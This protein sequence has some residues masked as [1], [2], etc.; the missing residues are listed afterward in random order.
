MGSGQCPGGDRWTDGQLL[1]G[2]STSAPSSWRSWSQGAWSVKQGLHPSPRTKSLHGH[3]LGLLPAGGATTHT[4]TRET[5]S[6]RLLFL[7][8]P[9][10]FTF[11]ASFTGTACGMKSNADY[12]KTS[13]IHFSSVSILPLCALLLKRSINTLLIILMTVSVPVQDD[14]DVFMEVHDLIYTQL[15][16]WDLQLEQ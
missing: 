6:C 12:C 11:S 8:I 16:W 4:G 15:N 7:Q 5:L 9:E 2:V 14:L 13:A 10:R 1:L 3:S